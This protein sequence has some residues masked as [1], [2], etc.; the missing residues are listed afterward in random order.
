M[1][2]EPVCPRP[3][4]DL[5]SNLRRDGRVDEE[6]TEA[7][8]AGLRHRPDEPALV[9]D[10]RCGQP[11][12]RAK[13]SALETIRP[14]TSETWTPCFVAAF[15]AARVSGPMIRS[16]PMSVPSMSSDELDGRIGGG[17][18]GRGTSR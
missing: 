6:A 2:I 10:D 9:A 18:V 14:V 17:V 4:D 11:S 8:R 15:T 1:R 16:S 3:L 13:R 12:S 5:A 7:L